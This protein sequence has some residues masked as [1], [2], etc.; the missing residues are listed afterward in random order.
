MTS[1]EPTVEKAAIDQVENAAGVEDI[2]N[3]RLAAVAEHET[4]LWQALKENRKAAFW[5]VMLS[6]TV[7]MEGYDV[8]QCEPGSLFY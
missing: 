1:H 6:T 3:A 4:T 7:I 5:S 2:K 8:G